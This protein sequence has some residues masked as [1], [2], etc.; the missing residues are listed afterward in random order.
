MAQVK[1]YKR[2]K[3]KGSKPVKLKQ[4]EMS[5][6]DL[7]DLAPGGAVVSG[8]GKAVQGAVRGVG[9]RFLKKASPVVRGRLGKGGRKALKEEVS[10]GSKKARDI[11]KAAWSR[12]TLAE[13]TEKQVKQIAKQHNLKKRP[14]P[15]RTGP[16]PTNK[17]AGKTWMSDPKTGNPIVNGKMRQ[18][19]KPKKAPKP[20]DGRRVGPTVT[21]G[22][23]KRKK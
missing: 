22:K 13:R 10:A 14:G 6:T 12:P 11:E 9:K 7:L 2:G 8:A 18:A 23:P 17:N 19:P 3:G 16:K 20:T 5:S 1:L 21:K 15:L 4:S